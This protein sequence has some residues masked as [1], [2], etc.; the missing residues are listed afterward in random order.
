MMFLR[1]KVAVPVEQGFINL[2]SEVSSEQSKMGV[3]FPMS[4]THFFEHYP[5]ELTN[6]FMKRIYIQLL[7]ISIISITKSFGQTN[8]TLR[9]PT[10]L[11]GMSFNFMHPSDSNK[12]FGIATWNI[13]M[14]S[15]NGGQTWQ[16]API[17]DSLSFVSSMDFP[18]RDVG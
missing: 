16:K 9:K 1:Q 2:F 10:P 8:W 7:I 17:Y 6:Y 3:F 11:P 12:V 18:G 5:N 15:T 13:G 4:F 14:R